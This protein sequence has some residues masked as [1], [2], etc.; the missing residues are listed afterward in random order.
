MLVTIFAVEPG[1]YGQKQVMKI[2][3]S[4]E[5]SGQINR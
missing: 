4:L 3:P 1:W 5:Q 2:W